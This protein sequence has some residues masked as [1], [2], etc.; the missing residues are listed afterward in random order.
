[1]LGELEREPH[2]LIV[3]G[4]DVAW[5]PM[6]V[7]TIERLQALAG[8]VRF[9]MGNTDREIVDAF[10]AGARESRDEE[11]IDRWTHWAAARLDRAHR[12]FLAGF[13]SRITVE[14][15]GLG[16]TLFCH[17]SPRSDEEIITLLTDDARLAPMLAGTPQRT[18]VCG[19]THCQFDRRTDGIRVINAGSVG[20][21]YEGV[22][23]AFWCLLGPDAELRR[24][25][26]DIGAAIRAMSAS[27]MPEL[28]EMFKE[29]LLEPMAPAEVAMVFERQA[30]ESG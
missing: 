16:E 19:H 29:S 27:G 15:D 12:D 22:P 20:I 7:E 1:V 5:G 17:G 21:P 9:V 28:E 14:I 2:D 23:G 13:E 10:D 26:Y 4:G 6:P 30:T 18:I 8:R 25:D 24:T 11:L 3:C